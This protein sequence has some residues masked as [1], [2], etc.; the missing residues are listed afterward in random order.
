MP[1]PHIA[2]KNGDFAKI[3]LMPGDPKRA[4]WIAENYLV[5]AKLVTDVRGILGFTGFT[6]KG[7]RVSVMAS[8]MGMPSIGIYSHELFDGYG[9]EAIIRIGTIGSYVPGLKLKDLLIAE[10]CCTDGNWPAQFG[11]NGGTYSAIADFDLLSASVAAAKRNGFRYAV[12]NLLS[13]DAFYDYSPDSW[14]KWAAIGVLGVEMEGYA[15]Y[16][17]A[18]TLHKKALSICSVSDSFC[19]DEKLTAAERQ[20]GLDS[21]IV[22]ALEV[23]D[24]FG[25]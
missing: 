16:C 23:V 8:G 19:S 10:G 12:G 5:D 3:V 20:E 25:G 9:V 14:K 24:G 6:K 1:T 11:L 13:S 4:R 21:M 22:T 7:T 18:A 17:T 2:A 15:L